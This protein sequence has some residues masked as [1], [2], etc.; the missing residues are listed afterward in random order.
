MYGVPADLDLAPFVGSSLLQ[1]GL[2]QFQIQLH[3]AGTGGTSIGS[4]SIEAHWELY[5]R[6]GT[7]LDRAVEHFERECYRIHVLLGLD[8]SAFSLA[9]PQSFTLSF[10]SGHRLTVFD[11]SPQYESFAIHLLGRQSIYV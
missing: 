8:V 1:I 6:D 9:S 2:G 7:L 3:F 11:D 5:R 10:A 4:I